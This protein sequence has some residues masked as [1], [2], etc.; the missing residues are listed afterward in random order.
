ME[1]NLMNVNETEKKKVRTPITIRN[2][3]YYHCDQ[4][5]TNFI[6]VDAKV[7]Q[8]EETANLNLKMKTR[9]N[10]VVELS[11][12]TTAFASVNSLKLELSKNQMALAYKASKGQHE[13]LKAYIW[14]GIEKKVKGVKASGI[15]F[16]KSG[17][18][19]VEGNNTVD[20]NGNHIEEIC[21]LQNSV[22]IRSSILEHDEPTKE[23]LE[24]L[25]KALLNHNENGITLSIL[26]WICACFL[27]SHLKECTHKLPH[28]CIAGEAGSGKSTVLE[29]IIL[30]VFSI[31]GA[32][33]AG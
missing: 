11:M 3:C 4:R 16:L 8:G 24:S 29:Q 2:S 1:N 26:A 14:G 25:L 20:K 23:Q 31:E 18:V 30:P 19:F 22:G 5:I 27:K 17:P 33:V 21:Q 32:K 6:V 12:P 15:Y 9:S 13:D 10:E 28:L 7:V